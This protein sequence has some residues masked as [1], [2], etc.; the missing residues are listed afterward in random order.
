VTHKT[1]I[2]AWDFD[3][4][5]TRTDS[6]FVFAKYA[7]GSWRYYWTLVK[8]APIALLYFTKI[9][10]ND[11][12][13]EHLLA[14]FYKGLPLSY[15]QQKALDFIEPINHICRPEALQRLTWHREQGH[16]LLLVSASAELWLQPW[17][18]SMG[19]EKVIA[20]KLETDN[21]LL[22]GKY[23]GKNCHGSEKIR[24]ILEHYPNRQSYTLYAY[25]D[26]DGDTQ[27]LE[28]A[29]RPYYRKYS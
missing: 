4:T 28:A 26:T 2:A 13:K 19:F 14:M 23:N 11:K 15:L 24:R 10:S 8:F 18:L 9:I 7:L 6:L 5:I 21:L 20:T 1:T 12:A 3:G 27:M 25:G 29:D 22:T 17:A 16:V